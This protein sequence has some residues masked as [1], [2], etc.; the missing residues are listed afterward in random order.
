VIHR[1]LSPRNVMVDSFG[2]TRILDFGLAKLRD[3]PLGP[4][5]SSVSQARRFARGNG[6]LQ[7]IAGALLG[8]AAYM[9]P[10]QARGVPLDA[11]SDLF[12]LGCDPLRARDRAEP[13]P[14][15]DAGR[16]AERV[17]QGPRASRRRVER[18]RA[19]RARTPGWRASWP[20]SQG[21]ARA[22][23]RSSCAR[24]RASGRIRTRLRA[25]LRRA[26]ARS[27]SCRSP[28]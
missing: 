11:R 4:L 28:T 23:R 21:S 10:E 12:S 26:S 18:R 2:H 15:P 19:A 13:V 5:S 1:D 27:R 20:R 14:G 24:S 9:S 16:H 17:H 7:T 8:T 6:E 3:E 22:R 25:P